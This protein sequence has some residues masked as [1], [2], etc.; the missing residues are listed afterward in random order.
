MK[1]EISKK[2]KALIDFKESIKE[3]KSL[4][5]MM[6]MNY[7]ESIDFLIGWLSAGGE[8]ELDESILQFLKEIGEFK[9]NW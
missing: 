5:S 8:S 9:E 7:Q 2:E 4:N 3:N 6:K 1:Y